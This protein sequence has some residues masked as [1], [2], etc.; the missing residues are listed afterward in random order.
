MVHVKAVAVE[1]HRPGLRNSRS[2]LIPLQQR[3][4]RVRAEPGDVAL[5]R[6][7]KR[8]KSGLNYRV[9]VEHKIAGGLRAMSQALL[10]GMRRKQMTPAK[11]L[12]ERLVELL[13]RRPAR[14][15]LHPI[16]THEATVVEER[17][18]LR[19]AEQA[20][21]HRFVRNPALV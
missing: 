17:G 1:P 7:L 3:M 18:V 20:R 4:R 16:G 21:R 5:Q 19:T 6:F 15:R 11:H 12:D 14:R 10:E 8:A 13:D 9:R 2:P